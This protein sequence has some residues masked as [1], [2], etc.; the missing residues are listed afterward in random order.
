VISLSS[1]SIVACHDRGFWRVARAV[2]TGSGTGAVTD[3]CFQVDRARA[4][5]DLPRIFRRSPPACAASPEISLFA[6]YTPP[7]PSPTYRICCWGGFHRQDEVK[8]HPG[9]GS[10]GGTRARPGWRSHLAGCDGL[11]VSFQLPSP[12]MAWLRPGVPSF[13]WIDFTCVLY[14]PF[15]H[16]LSL[17][18]KVTAA[19]EQSGSGD[20]H[21][22]AVRRGQAR[23]GAVRRGQARS[24]AVIVT[25]PMPSAIT[26]WTSGFAGPSAQ[27]G[28]K[29]P[30]VQIRPPRP[31]KQQANDLHL[32]SRIRPWLAFQGSLE[33]SWRRSWCAVPAD[34]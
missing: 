12:A 6:A 31:R 17:S 1:G 18:G 4:R 15:V 29:R 26:P 3:R 8:Q 10:L 30:P 7:S 16:N 20:K 23:S 14:A 13:R 5:L 24:G 21:S 28:T 2:L 9:H 34:D 32:P 19:W 11:V 33:K 22:G 25:A 27:F